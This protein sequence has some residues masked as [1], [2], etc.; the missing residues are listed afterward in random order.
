MIACGGTS[1]G[2][3][4]SGAFHSPTH[5]VNE[6]THVDVFAFYLAKHAKQLGS[7]GLWERGPF[8]CCC[9]CAV[10]RDEYEL[11]KN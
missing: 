11:V 2:A 5:A 3:I 1:G 7:T 9:L 8:S 4:C 6:A 10:H